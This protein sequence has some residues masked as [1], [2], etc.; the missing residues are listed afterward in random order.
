MSSVVQGEVAYNMKIQDNISPTLD[1]MTASEKNLEIQTK[2]TK[3]ETMQQNVSFIAQIAAVGAVYG[4]MQML[5]TSVKV[6]GLVSDETAEKLTKISASVG[7][8]FGSFQLLRGAIEIV[9]TLKSAEI[10]LAAVETY[11]AVLKSPAKL[12]VVAVAGGAA[13]GVAG[14]AI[15]ARGGGETAEQPVPLA[16]APPTLTVPP[17]ALTAPTSALATGM[18]GISGGNFSQA[19]QTRINQNITFTG[20]QTEGDRQFLSRES[21]QIMGG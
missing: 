20:V 17:P 16:S 5:T 18:Q 11:R 12:A 19:S 21:L 4:G 10:A 7:I 6:L 2:K 3:E 9:N 8:I 13:A 14:Y 1:K 15:G